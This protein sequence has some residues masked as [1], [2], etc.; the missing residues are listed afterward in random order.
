M[1]VVVFRAHGAENGLGEEY[2]A[3]RFGERFARNAL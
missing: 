1:I 2:L 3:A